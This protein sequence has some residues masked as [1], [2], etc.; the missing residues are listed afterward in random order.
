M[1]VPLRLPNVGDDND[2]WGD[3]LNQYLSVSLD[4]DGTIKSTAIATKIGTAVGSPTTINN[5]WVGDQTA[6]DAVSPKSNTTLY[7]IL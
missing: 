4:T 7:F 5:L 6:Y 1:T 3:I 2:T